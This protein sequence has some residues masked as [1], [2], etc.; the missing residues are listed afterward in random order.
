M[1]D[2]YTIRVQSSDSAGNAIED[3]FIINVLDENDGPT[4]IQLSSATVQEGIPVGTEIGIFSTTDADTN[5]SHVY[6]LV[7]GE[8]DE[9]NHLFAIDSNKLVTNDSIEFE[10]GAIRS[11]RIRSFDLGQS[12]VD[13]IFQI[14][15][16]DVANPLSFDVLAATNDS[17]P[18]ITG[19]GVPGRGG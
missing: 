1:K 17:T 3:T 4:A 14:T 5:D 6:Q 7:S 9:A 11:I 16:T 18:I 8:G 10:A 19:T 12:T 15:V 2:S 13:S